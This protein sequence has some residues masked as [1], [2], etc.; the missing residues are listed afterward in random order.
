V[1][2]LASFAG[3][4]RGSLV[5]TVDEKDSADLMQR[6]DAQLLSL[7]ME[8]FGNRLGQITQIGERF[9][10]PLTL[11]VAREQI[12]PGLVLLGNVA[13]ALHPVAGQGLNLALRDAHALVQVISESWA[14]GVKPGSM[15]VLQRYLDRQQADQ[16][17]VIGFTDS[18]TRLFSSNDNSQVWARKA[19]MLAIEL[20]PSLRRGLA[21]QAMGFGTN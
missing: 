11:S 15:A 6:T 10:Y 12:R 14:K 17:K 21:R 2:P 16:Q 20:L 1:L 13:H 9:C 19:G 7:L 8:R 5:W 4:N 18:M 3:Q